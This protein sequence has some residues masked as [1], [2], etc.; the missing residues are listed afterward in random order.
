LDGLFEDGLS[1]VRAVVAAEVFGPPVA[2][3]KAED[4]LH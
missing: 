2:L 4:R 1:L 3:R